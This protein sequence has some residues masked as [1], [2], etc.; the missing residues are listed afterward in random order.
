[1]KHMVQGSVGQLV[2]WSGSQSVKCCTGEKLI[3]HGNG[4]GNLI[5]QK[6]S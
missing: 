2:S 1:M 4:T 6:R 3:C 5:T